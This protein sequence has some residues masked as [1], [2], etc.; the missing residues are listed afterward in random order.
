MNSVHAN[1]DPIKAWV[2]EDVLYN[3]DESK[4]E[5]VVS[6]TIV[7]FSSYSGHAPSFQIVVGDSSI[8]YYVPPHLLFTKLDAHLV[9]NL[10][11]KDLVYHNCPDTEFVISKLNYLANDI[12]HVY[13]KSIDSWVDAEYLWTVDWYRGNDVLHALKLENGSIAFMP[14]HKISLG[15]KELPDYKKLRQ[16]WRV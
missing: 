13:L 8:F 9:T 1:I 16:E 4:S 7:A 3:M 6:C 2:R 12:V 10:S 15:K 5:K 14:N 11:L